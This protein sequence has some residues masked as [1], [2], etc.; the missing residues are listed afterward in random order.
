MLGKLVP[1]GGGPPIPLLKPRLVIGRHHACDIQ[2]PFAIVSGRHCELELRDGYWFV[3]DLGS[4]NGTRVNSALTTKQWLLPN[5]VLAVAGCRYTVVYVPPPN[6]PPPERIG[7]SGA[8]RPTPAR[9]LSGS[10]S[11]I[12]GSGGLLGELLPCG[13]G[14][15]IALRKSKLTVG[16]HPENDIVLRVPVVSGKHC[17]LE[18]K[19]G[20]WHVRDLNSRHGTRVDGVQCQEKVL[21]P[22]NVLWVANQRYKV[23][24]TPPGGAPPATQASMFAQSLL[25]AA[26]LARWEP[27]EPRGKEKEEEERRKQERHKIEE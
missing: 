3:S 25:A 4:S 1:C 5:D 16:R 21:M 23:A 9:P 24:Y 22:G 13:G 8:V 12:S 11:S 6:R 15:P 10:S 20:Y 26:G 17:E 18:L 14:D 2:L 27:P 7:A 19:D